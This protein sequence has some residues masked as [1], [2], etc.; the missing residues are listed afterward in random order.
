MAHREDLNAAIKYIVKYTSLC[1]LSK[2]YSAGV[3]P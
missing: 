3:M 1:S 2:K